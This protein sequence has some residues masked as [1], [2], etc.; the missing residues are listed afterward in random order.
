M[1]YFSLKGNY[2]IPLWRIDFD[3]ENTKTHLSVGE[4]GLRSSIHITFAF[5]LCS[6]GDG[7]ATAIKG[8]MPR[9][10]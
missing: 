7:L 1:V 8:R 9:E 3:S 6:Y 4:M 2:A 5:G 10:A